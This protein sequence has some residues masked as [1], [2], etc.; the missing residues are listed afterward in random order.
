MMANAQLLEDDVSKDQLLHLAGTHA[1]KK[2]E[3]TQQMLRSS[4][5]KGAFCFLFFFFKLTSFPVS[6]I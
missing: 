1:T 6:I 5:I 2:V 3:N 4:K